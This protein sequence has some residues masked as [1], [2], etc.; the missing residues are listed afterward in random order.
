MYDLELTLALTICA[1]KVEV[2]T[3]RVPTS[4]VSTVTEAWRAAFCPFGC[5]PL[6]TIPP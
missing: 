6:E 4:A 2:V 5:D 1:C 3:K